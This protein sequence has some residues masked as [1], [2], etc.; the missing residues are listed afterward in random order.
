MRSMIGAAFGFLIMLPTRKKVAWIWC[1]ASVS[2]TSGVVLGFGPSSNVKISSGSPDSVGP[3]A[4]PDQPLWWGFF[5]AFGS[6]GFLWCGLATDTGAATASAHRTR[7]F[8][9]I[10]YHAL[11]SWHCFR[12]AREAARPRT[13]PRPTREPADAR[14]LAALSGRGYEDL[15]Q[16]RRPHR[17]RAVGQQGSQARIF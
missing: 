5:G 2:R 6:A 11:C 8:T 9:I 1:F 3:A 10:R 15:G 14:P 13:S 4:G 12:H 16:A 7:S 17:Q